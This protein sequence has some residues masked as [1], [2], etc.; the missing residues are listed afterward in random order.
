[1]KTKKINYTLAMM[2]TGILLLLLAIQSSCSK[3][4]NDADT[5]AA[6]TIKITD[7]P[8]DDTAVSGVFVTITDIKLDS[9]SVAGFTKTTV[10]LATLQNG[11]TSN[12]GTF[13]LTGKTYSSISFVLNFDTTASGTSPGCYVLS[14]GGVK[15]KLQSASNTIT[16][17]KS[18]DLQAGTSNSLVAD[19]DLRKM[20]VRQSGGN[21][22]DMY[23]F[24]T[25][26]EL[27]HDIRVV[28]ENKTGTIS[29]KLTDS[30][31][32]YGK[33]VAYAYKKGTFNRATE[34]SGQGASNVEFSNAVASA[35]VA[36]DGTYQLHFLES[37]AYEI[38]YASYKDTNADG[39]LELKGTLVVLGSGTLDPLNLDL[40]IN[41][42]I[43]VNVIA[44]ALL[45]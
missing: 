16:I 25:N 1:M 14:S 35:V 4:N 37:G 7:A 32:L 22:G 38:H 24:A 17:T 27:Q 21:P 34:L 5:A 39:I 42:T 3:D 6:T 10:N 41:T 31:S 28:A 43:T 40:G 29:G 11:N 20:L 23:D 45:P 2:Y 13:N 15:H 26:A 30:L 18:F 12:L 36:A 33:K 9:Q 19:F 8:I 44:T